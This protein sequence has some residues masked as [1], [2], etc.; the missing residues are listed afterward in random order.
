M[1]RKAATAPRADDLDTT[2]EQVA[3]AELR[4][5]PRNYHQHPDDELVHLMQ[6]LTTHGLYRNPVIAQD[7]TILAGH[8]VVAAAHRVGYTHLSVK[9]MPYGPDD[10]RALQLLVGDNAIAR[11]AITHEADLV[12]LLQ[13]L[14]EHDPLALLGTGFDEATLTALAE[15]QGLGNGVGPSDA[16]RDAEPQIDRAEELREQWGVEVGQLWA[17][18]EHRVICG[19]CTDKAVVERLMKDQRIDAILTDPPYGIGMDHMLHALSGV[20]TG[21]AWAPHRSYRD[22][23]WDHQPPAADHLAS[24]L[25]LAPHSIIWGG[26]F[27]TL[28]PTRCYL[29]WDKETGNNKY[30]DCE[31]AWTNLNKPVRLIRHLWK[32]MLRANGEERGPHPAQ[33]PVAVMEWALQQFPDEPRHVLDV[34]LGSGTTLI[35]CENLGRICYGCELDPGYT[36]VT[37]ERWSTL[38]SDQPQRLA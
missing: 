25:L 30:A 38:T 13:E 33:K 1:A 31:L 12:Q 10:P 18:G 28:P 35:A 37:L 5:H 29:V 9:R 36:A 4:P 7:G 24:L 22:T 19:D 11:L 6:S 27:F 34:Y 17:C 15:A 3:L 2:L 26:H 32:G 16:G 20:Q 14:S 23:H 8:G 21:R